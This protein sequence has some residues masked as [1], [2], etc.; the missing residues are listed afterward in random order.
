LNETLKNIDKII[1]TNT[2]KIQKIEQ[3]VRRNDKLQVTVTDKK[4]TIKFQEE[5]AIIYIETNE[6]IEQLEKDYKQAIKK[7]EKELADLKNQIKLLKRVPVGIDTDKL[8][9]IFATKEQ[10]NDAIKPIPTILTRITNM[11]L[12]VTNVVSN[13]SANLI[14]LAELFQAFIKGGSRNE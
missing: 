13:F 7:L 14:K 9:K 12:E 5:T 1:P 8:K 3:Q 11:E 10:L 6:K 2:E 4:I